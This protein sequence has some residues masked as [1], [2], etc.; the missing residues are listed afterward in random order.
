LSCSL[1]VFQSGLIK[2]LQSTQGQEG[3]LAPAL[4]LS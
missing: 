1:K 4:S 3:G 2:H